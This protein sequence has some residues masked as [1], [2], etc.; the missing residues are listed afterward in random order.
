[1]HTIKRLFMNHWLALILA[2]LVS[3]IVAFP[4]LYFRFEHRNDGIYQGIELLPDSPW[5]ARAREI[6][7]GHGFGSIYYKY[8]K[9]DP[10]LHLPLGSMVVAYM[11][12]IFSLDINNTILLSRLVLPFIAF[13]LIYSFVFLISRN[14]SASLCSA[15]II[16][17]ADSLLD[18]SGIPSF[19]H[20][21]FQG[22]SSSSFLEIARPVYS[23]MI[24]VPFFGFLSSFWLFY[25]DRKWYWGVI[26]AIV[27]GLNFY[28]YFY[29]WTYAYAFGFVLI[30]ILLL[31]KKWREAIRMAGV[32]LLALLV[33]IPYFINLYNARLHPLYEELSLRHGIVFSHTPLFVGVLVLIAVVVFLLGFPRG[34]KEKYFF[35]LALL[36]T[37][38]VTMNQQLVTGMS[39]QTGH[40]HWYFHKP[41]A[42][43]FIFVTIFHFFRQRG[44]HFYRRM[45]AATI[46]L[47]SF[48]IGFFVQGASYFNDYETRDGGY[49]AIERQRYG[50]V[51]KWLSEFAEK[52]TVVLGNNEASQMIVIYTPLNVFYHRSAQLFLSA[53]EERLLDSVFTLFRL[54]RVGVGGAREVF[55]ANIN[56]ISADVYGIY[57]RESHGSYGAIPDEKFNEILGRYE[58]ALLAP[59]SVWFRNIFD[60][61]EVEYIVWDKIKNPLWKLERFNFLDEM[62]DFGQ[63][64]I[65]RF[66]PPLAPL[67]N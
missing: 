35:G 25:R 54:D 1:M 44:W 6:Q 13:L 43:I 29:I 36:V 53:T 47:V 2:M 3:L 22:I 48:S 49:I 15:I 30:V 52:E 21:M 45:L 24:F 8:G 28:N 26:S 10:Y 65:Y 38:F 18:Y 41:I 37:P 19:L 59:D 34:D 39:L 63:M 17:L 42:V 4:Q 32:F 62:A 50:P 23:L 7:D 60:K 64:A 16:L 46:I 31:R 40:Y 27:L 9:D 33:A 51:V 5:S 67:G 55:L 61:Y 11:G 14:K 66:N 57:Y 58:K 12:K 20:N 56:Q